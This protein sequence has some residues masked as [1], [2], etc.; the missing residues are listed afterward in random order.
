MK[1]IIEGLKYDTDTA[2]EVGSWDN[3]HYHGD[4]HQCQESMY[5][6]KSGKFFLHGKGGPLSSYAVQEGNGVSG[7]EDIRPLSEQE[8]RRW[9]EEHLTVEE[10]EDAFGTAQEA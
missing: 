9:A 8:S 5:R 4:F 6:T 3:G 10:I 7:S 2:E 1:K